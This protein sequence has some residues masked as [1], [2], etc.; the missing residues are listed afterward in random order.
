MTNHKVYIQN[1]KAIIRDVI[2]GLLLYT[3]CDYFEYITQLQDFFK[4]QAHHS[5]RNE[6]LGKVTKFHAP[7]ISIK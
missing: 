2:I 3:L 6:K 1:I 4:N 7:T 5:M